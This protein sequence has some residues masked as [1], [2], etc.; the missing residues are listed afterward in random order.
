MRILSSTL[1]PSP[2]ALSTPAAAPSTSPVPAE[3]VPADGLTSQSLLGAAQPNPDRASAD[4]R[5]VADATAQSP[6][7]GAACLQQKLAVLNDP[8]SRRDLLLAVAPAVTQ[9]GR[10]CAA[11]TPHEFVT[12]SA[13]LST[14]AELAGPSGAALLATAFRDGLVNSGWSAQRCQDTTRDALHANP[15]QLFLSALSAELERVKLT[16]AGTASAELRGAAK[17]ARQDFTNDLQRVR[18]QQAILERLA[19]SF[20]PCLSP[21][22]LEAAELAFAQRSARDWKIFEASG[23]RL[24]AL[25]PPLADAAKGDPSPTSPDREEYLGALRL[26]PALGLTSAGK[27]LLRCAVLNQACHKTSVLD[28]VNDAA[29]LSPRPLQFKDSLAQELTAAVS[30]Q[31]ALLLQEKNPVGARNLVMDSLIANANLIGVEGDSFAALADQAALLMDHGQ[32]SNTAVMRRVEEFLRSVDQRMHQT[33]A[34]RPTPNPLETEQAMGARLTRAARCVS[35]LMV[36]L[37]AFGNITQLAHLGNQSPRQR[38]LTLNA[39]VDVATAAARLAL[40]AWTQPKAYVRMK[41]GLG[42]VNGLTN[43]LYAYNDLSAAKRV[44]T[45]DSR[46]AAFLITAGVGETTVAGASAFGALRYYDKIPKAV[47]AAATAVGLEDLNAVPGIGVTLGTAATLVGVGGQ[48]LLEYQRTRGKEQSAA[49]D[50]QFF[51]RGAGLPPHVAAALSSVDSHGVGIGPFIAQVA[52]FVGTTATELFEKIATL[53]PNTMAEFMRIVHAAKYSVSPHGEVRYSE[54]PEANPDGT[55]ALHWLWDH[56]QP[57]TL[58]E[59]AMEL[60]REGCV[61]EKKL[62]QK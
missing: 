56:G 59:A 53:S 41:V 20:G 3:A 54:K 43:G 10:F 45:E 44:K 55:S 31:A 24:A 15:E 48:L 30:A 8:R 49:E 23:T 58:Q 47:V 33:Q 16:Q 5:E 35:A 38:V 9:M 2:T 14:V 22:Q 27:D 29:A 6:S 34:L 52:P 46:Q 40:Y 7:Q 32:G 60:K 50:V 39:S 18:S 12:L 42:I 19:V 11:S 25:L 62:L 13:R 36:G 51:L 21:A 4:A 17:M 57:H 37:R 61:P 26:L 1:L 28:L